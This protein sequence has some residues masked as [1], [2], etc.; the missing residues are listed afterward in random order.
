MSY[1]VFS[2]PGDGYPHVRVIPADEPGAELLAQGYEFRVV[3]NA[4][5]LEALGN[6]IWPHARIEEMRHGKQYPPQDLDDRIRR[7][8]G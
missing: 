5:W 7:A 4:Q 1:K 2:K 6:E 8:G 3:V